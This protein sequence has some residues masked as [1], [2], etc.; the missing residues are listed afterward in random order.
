M[1][2]T[3]LPYMLWLCLCFCLVRLHHLSILAITL[4]KCPHAESAYSYRFESSLTA[5]F[6]PNRRF[7]RQ[8]LRH[9][10]HTAN[11]P[12]PARQFILIR[13]LN[14]KKIHLI[15]NL[16]FRVLFSVQLGFLQISNSY[17]T[18]LEVKFSKIPFLK[19]T[20]VIIITYMPNINPIH[21]VVWAVH[22]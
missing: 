20:Y 19:H 13:S 7:P 5:R 10:R 8:S 18:P 22:W 3:I 17:F 2:S 16:W 6:A 9:I 15:S 11:R 21:P 4:K 1:A 14:K 12:R